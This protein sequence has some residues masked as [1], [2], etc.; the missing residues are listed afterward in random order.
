MSS[1]SASFTQI[2]AS[3]LRN[4][5]PPM[6]SI[7]IGVVLTVII[8]AVLSAIVT[9]PETRTPSALNGTE[10]SRL[11]RCFAALLTS[12]A[13]RVQGLLISGF[14][15]RVRDPGACELRPRSPPRAPQVSIV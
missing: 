2:L 6:S 5:M 3:T 15:F 8:M 14:R 7:D 11:P 10:V 1:A 4:M 13:K 9:K 12:T